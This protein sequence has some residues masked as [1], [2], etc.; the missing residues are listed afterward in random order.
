MIWFNYTLRVSLWRIYIFKTLAVSFWQFASTFYWTDFKYFF[1]LHMKI[2]L[3][4]QK[5][6]LLTVFQFYLFENKMFSFGNSPRFSIELIKDLFIIS[7]GSDRAT[8]VK[9]NCV[10]STRYNIFTFSFFL[11]Y[12]YT[13][14]YFIKVLF[15]KTIWKLC[16]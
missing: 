8:S 3:G 5:R 2:H 11:Y 12:C 10:S 16:V 6:L 7:C 14:S 1:F 13:V 4:V 9:I 15:T